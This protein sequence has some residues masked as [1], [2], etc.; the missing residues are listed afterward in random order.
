M[1][2]KIISKD[3]AETPPPQAHIPRQLT[4]IPD[5]WVVENKVVN[6]YCVLLWALGPT[7]LLV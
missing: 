6:V 7:A 3:K 5:R 2:Y 1:I 4:F